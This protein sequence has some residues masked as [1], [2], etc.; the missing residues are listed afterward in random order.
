M[1]CEKNT[2]LTSASPLKRLI[3]QRS[4]EI[5]YAWQ[6]AVCHLI[7]LQMTST[8]ITVARSNTKSKFEI[9]K[10]DTSACLLAT[11]V[12]AAAV[13][14]A[15]VVWLC[16]SFDFAIY[17]NV[18]E[19]CSTVNTLKFMR[20]LSDVAP[21]LQPSLLI[22]SRVENG[23]AIISVTVAK[24][25]VRKIIFVD[26]VSNDWMNII[27]TCKRG[28]RWTER[29]Q[30]GKYFISQKWEHM[31]HITLLHSF[32]WRFFLLLLRYD[33]HHPF[34]WCFSTFGHVCRG[35]VHFTLN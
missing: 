14:V 30:K 29:K 16:V 6:C 9:N 22:D 17:E 1:H 13:A 27:S 34:S 25:S 3:M 11:D 18:T 5:T 7:L 31:S 24:A 23:M 20:I 8:I 33:S 10:T 15:V 28:K 19:C 35:A 21:P 32:I 12:A 26:A 4:T 2:D